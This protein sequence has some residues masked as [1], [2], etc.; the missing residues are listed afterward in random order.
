MVALAY[1]VCA[2]V[3]GTTWFAIRVCIAP[4]GYAPLTAAALRFTLA[5]LVIGLAYAIGL[6]RP[7]P[8][9]RRDLGWMAAAGLA[10]AGS[11]GLL[12]LAERYISGGLAATLF[13]LF[14][15]AVAFAAAATKTERVTRT[16][17]LGSLVGLVGVAIIFWDRLSVSG[18]QAGAVGMVLL[19]VV[20]SAI[21]SV[22]FKRIADRQHP[23]AAV[24]VFAA[25]TGLALWLAAAVTGAT[26]LPWP[27]PLDPSLA[28]VY[29]AVLGTVLVFGC[30]MY[31]LRHISLMAV[32][33]LVFI[34]PVIAMAVDAAFEHSVSLDTGTYVGAVVVFAGVAINVFGPRLVGANAAPSTSGETGDADDGDAPAAV[35][36]S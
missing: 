36:S 28:V 11:Y 2:L 16:A 17:V 27:P 8:R 6:A 15:L 3:W 33:T 35:A 30:Y 1:V 18:E 25:F 34:E 10:N 14:P 9:G 31:L 20:L 5:A 19:A 29:L 4:G 13:A 12:Y 21:Y 7:G 26:A 22:I 24:G 23:V 32:S